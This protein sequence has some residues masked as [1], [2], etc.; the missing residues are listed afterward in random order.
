VHA[1]TVLMAEDGDCVE[2]QLVGCTEDSN[3]DL[4]SVGD[5]VGLSAGV[6]SL[7]DAIGSCD[8]PRS[9]F[10]CM[11][12]LLA[13]R[14]WCTELRWGWCSPCSSSYSRSSMADEAAAGFSTPSEAMLKLQGWME[15]A[16]GGTRQWG[17]GGNGAREGPRVRQR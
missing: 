15:R 12:E 4:S 9:F 5:W 14:R 10:N 16:R 2:G 8:S 11:M 13:R 7:R 6:G 3:G 1:E 17:R